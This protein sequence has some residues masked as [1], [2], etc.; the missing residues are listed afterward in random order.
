MKY[1]ERV[2]QP[3][4]TVQY[5]SNVH[6]LVYLPGV[7]LIVVGMAGLVYLTLGAAPAIAY[8]AMAIGFGGGLLSLAAAWFRR[9]TTEIAITN[10]RIIYKRGFI[11]RTT[12]EMNM[13][14]VESVVVDQSI[15]GRMF[16]YGDIIIRGSGSGLEPIRMIDAP[17]QFRSKVTAR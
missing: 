9:W 3:G 6:R 17:L 16:D 5:T 11:R 13:D 15:L 8:L 4:E 1:V 12:I 2:L 7:L 10:R 14:K